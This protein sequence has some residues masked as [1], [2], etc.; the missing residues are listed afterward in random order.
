MESGYQPI[1]DYG[2]IGNLRTAALVGMDGSLDWLC[3]PNFDSPSVFA[4]ILDCRKGGRFCIFRARPP[5]EGQGRSR[6]RPCVVAGDRAPG[7]F[8]P[9]HKGFAVLPRLLQLRCTRAISPASSAACSTA[10]P[11]RRC[12]HFEAFPHGPSQDLPT[13]RHRARASE[14]KSAGHA[15]APAVAVSPAWKPRPDTP[16]PA[17]A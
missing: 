10:D 16:P 15:A 12:R 6:E 13:G 17:R 7:G 8:E 3:L 5:Q 1:E 14:R 2:L 4:A 9:P 11:A